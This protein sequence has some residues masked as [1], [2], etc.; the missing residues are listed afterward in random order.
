MNENNITKKIIKIIDENPIKIITT[1][2]ISMGLIYLGVYYF[3]NEFFPTLSTEEFIQL[4]FI[5]FA[6]SFLVSTALTIGMFM[7]AEHLYTIFSEDAKTDEKIFSG[8]ILFL[9]FIMLVSY[10]IWIIKLFEYKQYFF[11]IFYSVI[12]IFICV[13]NYAYYK[14]KEENNLKK[15][16]ILIF[17]IFIIL[18]ILL[19]P[20]L[21]I[22]I[23]RVFHLGN[24]KTDLIINNEIICNIITHNKNKTCSIKGKVIWNIGNNY[25]LE[26]NNARY[27]IPSQY[28]LM[29]KFK[30]SQKSNKNNNSQKANKNE[31]TKKSNT[32]KK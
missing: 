3:N 6:I 25:L 9:V 32:S 2:I 18:N 26:I 8:L 10:I 16:S 14:S 7:P 23:S 13:F 29:E 24:Y 12:F 15:L 27:K 1:F 17:T 5:F 19:S 31:Q 20:I 30:T 28:I 22:S 11:G 21:T 4:S